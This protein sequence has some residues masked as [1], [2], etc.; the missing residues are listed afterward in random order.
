MPATN[1][2]FP[3]WAFFRPHNT[4][5]RELRRH[6]INPND[7]IAEE[8][9]A[10]AYLSVRQCGA[11]APTRAQ[12]DAI[13]GPVRS[14]TSG[15]EVPWRNAGLKLCSLG[16]AIAEI[17]AEWRP[18]CSDRQS[19]KKL[20]GVIRL[21]KKNEQAQSASTLSTLSSMGPFMRS[22]ASVLEFPYIDVAHA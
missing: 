9:P 16:L 22:R 11:N 13:L 10:P 15:R 19:R 20:D 2:A 18:W 4:K 3:E 7:Y 17:E 1:R 14:L 8:E 12:I 21:L 6:A 5:T